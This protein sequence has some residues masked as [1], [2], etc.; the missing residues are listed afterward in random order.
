MSGLRLWALI[1][2]TMTAFAANSLLNR[3]AVDG[4]HIDPLG[5]AILRVLA[6]ALMLASLVLIKGHRPAMPP[7]RR[8]LAAAGLALYLV[9]FSVA[10]LH[11]DA[12]LGALILFGGVQVAMFGAALGLGEAVPRA[13]YLGAALAF[14]GLALLVWPGGAAAPSAIGAGA[15]ALAALGW[16]LYTLLGRDARDPLAETAASFLI[17][18]PLVLVPLFLLPAQPDPVAPAPM[19]IA[20]AVL[21]GAV[22]SGL[23]YALWYAVLRQIDATTAAL[24]QLSAPLIAV[25]GGALLLG[26]VVGLRLLLA[27]LAILGGIALG[28]ALGQRKIGSSGS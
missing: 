10:Y 22:T 28:I 13:R 6:G 9:G 20:L 4:G 21:S 24:V 12:G 16:A 26:E 27:A 19:G 25:A 5:F 23:G 2:V 7:P 3:L 14:A 1:A 17:A 11:L 8:Y 18:V 15:M